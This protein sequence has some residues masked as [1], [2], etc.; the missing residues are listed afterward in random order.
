[1]SLGALDFGLIVDGAV[2]I[3]ENCLR[4]LSEKQQALARS[5]SID[6][7]LAEVAA[8][9]R[10]MIHPT[11]FGQAIILTVYLPLLTFSGVEGKMFEPMA[12]TVI[13][14][15]MAAFILS[16]T[17]TPA[18][19]AIFVKPKSHEKENAIVA[20]AKRWY[21]PL[22]EK[23]LQNP[24][25]VILCSVA[26]VSASFMLFLKLGQEFVPT[27]DEKDIALHA[28]RIPSTSLTQS[29]AMQLQVEK[30]LAQF[31]EVAF[32]FSKTGTAEMASDPM[33]PNVSDTF[34]MLKPPQEWP[35]PGKSKIALIEEI[36]SALRKLPGNN[37]EFTQPIEMRFNELIAGVRSDVAV[38]IYGDD[39]NVM[40]KIAEDIAR[41]LRRI[42]GAADV[43]TAQTDGLPVL[44]VKIDREVSKRLGLNVADILEVVSTAI[45]GSKAGIL[46]EGDR[47]FDIMVRLPEELRQDPIALGELPI[48]LPNS[49]KASFPY[50][51]LRSLA[52]LEMTEG[53]NEI[54]RENGKRVV[55]VQANVRGS[56]I[57]TFV[58]TAKE[59]T[60]SQVKIPPGY[61]LEWGGQF[62]N[63]ISAREH[64][65]I[66]VPL[67]FALIFLLLFSSLHSLK[68]ALMVF[69][70]VPMA[71]TGGIFAL[72]LS[73][74]PFSISAAVGFIALSGI[75]VLNG[76]VMLTYI[77]QLSRQGFQ[78]HHAIVTGA[79]TRLRPVLMT[80]L[81]A[82][83]G[84]V[85]MAFA[86]GTGAEVQ[87]PLAI[88]VI[89]GLIS[90]TGL[91]LF[92]LPVLC[93]LF[94]V[95]RK[96]LLIDPSR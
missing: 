36:E 90:S 31:P 19:I 91:T 30:T 87:K 40:Q 59:K 22:L 24:T 43:K 34:V 45:G 63:L 48:P 85:P 28:V 65:A 77:N 80:A 17:F 54:S 75:A 57:G 51:P 69:S 11:V 60:R 42:H 62:E 1:M 20:T 49:K 12:M 38:K 53:L 18:M 76:L 14:A 66:V 86:M 26:L 41:V 55:I 5:L 74:M 50:V 2:I 78:L 29:T 3:S 64:L 47:R 44:E 46:F 95:K 84:F 35:D 79:L 56:D 52:K 89:G 4:K 92:V 58:S 67:C 73:G 72:W 13:F 81:V 71:L 6:E 88:V 94:L 93:Q 70:G 96:A 39:F 8:A 33:P 10:E 16:L 32:A 27:L 82:S 15:L 9:S 25:P 37:Y 21:R 7:R 23:S 83:L 61:W 68:E